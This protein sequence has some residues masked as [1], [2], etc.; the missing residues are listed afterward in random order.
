MGCQFRNLKIETLN[1]SLEDIK[2]LNLPVVFN[3]GCD[4][5]EIVV[6]GEIRIISQSY[7]HSTKHKHKHTCIS[8]YEQEIEKSVLTARPTPGM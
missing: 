3:R 6:H 5:F 8:T 1:Q 2:I 7:I 4:I